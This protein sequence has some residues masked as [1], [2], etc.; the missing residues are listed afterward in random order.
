MAKAREE[1]EQ[2]MFGALDNLFANTN[3]KAKDIDQVLPL[4]LPLPPPLPL[5]LNPSRPVLHAA[6]PPPHADDPSRPVLHLTAHPT[7]FPA[8][9]PS[10]AP[11]LIQA[12]SAI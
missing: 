10:Q 8:P 1:A 9:L 11:L 7:P 12:S 6:N 4:L 5:P 3:V 2:V